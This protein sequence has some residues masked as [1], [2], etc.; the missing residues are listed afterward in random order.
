MKDKAEI[1]TTLRRRLDQLKRM[2]LDTSTM[3]PVLAEAI[4]L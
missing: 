3:L 2:K 4:T 1:F